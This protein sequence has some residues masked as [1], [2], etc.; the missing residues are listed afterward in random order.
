MLPAPIA[1]FRSFNRELSWLDFNDRVM[2]LAF[3]ASV[4]LL[5]RV[6]FAAICAG[7]MD[8][9]FEV[10]VAGVQDRVT[11]GLHGPGADGM[12]P[13]D[14]LRSVLDRTAAFAERH[15]K[16]VLDV[17]LPELSHYGIEVVHWINTTDQE[18]DEASS[19]YDR[20]LHPVL[21][22][23][24]VDPAHPFP[25]IS[26][27]SLNIGVLIS[28]G[29]SERFARVKVPDVLPR[30]VRLTS[31]GRFILLEHLI[32]A[33]LGRLFGDVMITGHAMFRVTRKSDLSVDSDE[34]DDL[35]EAVELELRRRRFGKAVRIEF[36]PAADPRIAELLMREL[37]LSPG[38]AVTH[39]G[40]LGMSSLHQL[41]NVDLPEHHFPPRVPRVP[42]WLPGPSGGSIFEVL[43]DGDRFVHHPY[44]A[45]DATV[46][47]FVR[48]AAADPATEAIKMALYRTSRDGA[49]IDALIGAARAGVQVVALVELFARF[50]EGANIA[51]ARQLEDAGVHVV[52]GLVGLK[53]H[54]KC[55][56]V[57]RR[58]G[59]RMRRYAHIGTG[60]YNATTA[61][62]YEDG[63]LFTADPDI[64]RDVG[65]L[66]NH[67]TGFSAVD[68]YRSL[69]VAP[70]H[71]RN[72]L[73]RLIAVE[74]SFGQAGRIVIKSNAVVDE[75][76]IQALY[77]ASQAG[78]AIELI[79]RG[80]CCLRP[81]VEGL[82]KGIRVRSILGRFL[83][84]SRVYSFANGE[85]VGREALLMGS[86]DLMERNLDR[87][88]EVLVPITSDESRRRVRSILQACLE[89][90][91][92]V[93]S[94]GSDG[95]WTSIGTPTGRSA[96]DRL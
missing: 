16:L 79:V 4:P 61:A 62:I 21:T 54:A 88:V 36:G 53:T 75:E 17:L 96:Q 80:A 66:F 15:D 14:V 83:E 9:F 58:E 39:R 92:Y 8:E 2:S 29:S 82:S 52:Y 64:G 84:H 11:N 57:V 73:L 35:L 68:S 28:A 85:G 18:R 65:E 74:A 63:G 23:L 76:M 33:H 94:L 86:A 72:E 26:N 70:E 40:P 71:L 55:V 67:L 5:E 69:V 13:T 31:T 59:N 49:V 48:A 34:A 87:R 7:N 46:V 95:G 91:R 47:E 41:A 90:D 3:D 51:W 50:D 60:N 25:A 1:D 27:L 81:G 22:P 38:A 24:A 56:L 89:D 32:G 44:E 93:W 30:F 10:R 20:L 77:R 6:R 19:L 43:R 78:V 45:F 37:H 12:N 42:S